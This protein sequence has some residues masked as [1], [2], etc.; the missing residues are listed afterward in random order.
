M[1]A[2]LPLR[3]LVTGLFLLSGVGFTFATDRRSLTS[4]VSHGLH[5]VM[6]TAMVVMA[7]PQGLRLPTTPTE[8]FFLA[9]ALWFV[10]TAVL[11]AR[12]VAQ[13]V[14]RI[15]EA[16]M[17]FAM[18]WMYSVAHH[19]PAIEEAGAEHHHHHHM[20]PGMPMPDMDMTAPDAHTDDLPNWVDA[21]NWIWT[22]VFVVA[23]LVWG[24]RFATQ[25]GAGRRRRSRTWR[26][27]VLSAVQMLMAAGMAIMFATLLFDTTAD[28][29]IAVPAVL[30]R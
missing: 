13:R 23:A 9:A 22:V 19:H 12:V 3:W 28:Q 18:A 1:I 4:V 14:V 8:V 30:S 17:M 15:Y 27:T 16:A 20:P 2:D 24:Y 25:R 11:T 5:I 29:A 26:K 7:W 10:M 6:V 21:G